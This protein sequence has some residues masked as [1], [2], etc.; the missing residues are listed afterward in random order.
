MKVLYLT[1]YSRKGASSRM[2]S[3]QYFPYL[4]TYGIDITVKPFFSDD[5]L[6]DLYLNKSRTVNVLRAYFNRFIVLFSAPKY[7]LLVFEKEIF[8][9]LPAWAEWILSKTGKPYIV[10]YD[11]AIFHNYDL[12]P[13]PVFRKLLGNKIDQVMKYS[14][15][16]VAGNSYLAERAQMAG[17]KKIEII[18]TVIDLDRYEVKEKDA[19][20]SD[21]FVVG[22]IGTKSTFEKHFIP[23]LGWM[24]ELV[25]SNPDIVFHIIG[26]EKTASLSENFVF[27]PWSE[28]SEV[29]EIQRMDIGIMPLQ[30]TL[31]ER[32]KCA[33]KLIQYAAC[34]IPG[35]AS[36]VGMNSEVTQ[37]GI[38]GFLADSKVSWK[39]HIIKLKDI[40][41]LRLELGINARKLI[42][43]KYCVQHTAGQ[44][45]NILYS[46]IS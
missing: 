21:K 9:Y 25:E 6:E 12:H 5:Y 16:V 44:W 31:W 43:D 45:V 24:K 8:P 39:D 7:D 37:H 32:G 3:Y 2:R 35:V 11:D 1:K 20:K 4:K 15:V 42:E 26:P 18:P 29:A 10:D 27:I 46:I 34:G 36:A 22:W 14:T 17:A 28:K 41:S 13:N 38:T 19:T 30:D 33:Y 40:R 23:C